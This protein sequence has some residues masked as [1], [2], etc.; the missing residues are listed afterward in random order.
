LTQFGLRELRDLPRR[1]VLLLELPVPTAAAASP[2]AA[3]VVETEAA[4]EGSEEPPG[5]S[6]A[7]APEDAAGQADRSD[8]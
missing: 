7:D 6:A 8:D 2:D 1:E 5:E 4:P 3:E